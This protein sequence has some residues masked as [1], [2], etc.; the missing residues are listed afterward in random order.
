MTHS[1]EPNRRR[2]LQRTGQGAGI[3]AA[4]LSLGAPF[5]LADKPNSDD[6]TTPWLRKTLKIGMIRTKGS[7]TERFKLAKAAGFE[8]VELHAPNIKVDEAKEAAA[9]SG[10]II[11]GTVGGY[12]WGT[13]H[14]DPDPEV[15]AKALTLLKQGLE[16]TAAVGG[17]SML[18][19]PGHG[20]DGTDDEV[21]ER[22]VQA[23]KAALPVAEKH[24]VAI[25]IE[26]VWNDFCYDHE[27]GDDQT[28]DR[29]AA[30]IDEF[31]TP[32]VGV[33][34][35]IGNHWKYG[36]PAA[37]IRTLGDRVQKL[38]IKGYSRAKQSWADITE[39]DID[40][41]EVEEALHDIDFTGWLAAEVGGGDLE[42]LK[43]ISS[44]LEAALHC[45]KSIAS[46]S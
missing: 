41:P 46:V 18:L 27:G 12:H 20:K 23:I 14:T 1:T 28:A 31:D 29:L 22:A 37:W 6:A 11:D 43:T 15:R 38:D 4:S 44:Q 10:L 3:A 5:V 16:N 34:F 2:F 36:D 13:R 39:G 19:V 7:L 42:R 8:G 21:Y 35:D 17:E 24:N 33:Q 40:W 9:A 25:L 32:L 30:F 26:N 45:S